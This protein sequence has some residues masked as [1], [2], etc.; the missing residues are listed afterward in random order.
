MNAANRHF[1]TFLHEYNRTV[2]INHY[3]ECVNQ[4]LSILILFIFYIFYQQLESLLSC[5]VEHSFQN[6]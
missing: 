6:Q 3:N 2:S 5:S 4:V 1:L